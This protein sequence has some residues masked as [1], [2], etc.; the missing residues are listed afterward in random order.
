[1]VCQDCG[2]VPR[3]PESGGRRCGRLCRWKGWNRPRMRQRGRSVP[4]CSGAR[5]A[6]HAERGGLTLCREHDDRGHNLETTAA[7]R[8]EYLTAACEAA[9]RGE[10]APSLLPASAQQAQAVA[11]FPFSLPVRLRTAPVMRPC[12]CCHMGREKTGAQTPMAL[13]KAIGKASM[14]ILSGTEHGRCHCR[15]IVT[16]MEIN[17]QSQAKTERRHDL[18]IGLFINRYEFGQ[19]L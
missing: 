14:A 17:G 5:G 10:A 2:D 11:Y 18:V 4:V 13:R 19:P 6:W 12:T 15:S 1:M 9:L 8:L 3:H 16:Q 7:Q